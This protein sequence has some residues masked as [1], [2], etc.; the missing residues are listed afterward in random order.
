VLLLAAA[1][2]TTRTTPAADVGTRDGWAEAS[3]TGMTP[4]TT[5]AALSPEEQVVADYLPTGPRRTRW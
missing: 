5:T 3:T 1:G 2:V 4:T